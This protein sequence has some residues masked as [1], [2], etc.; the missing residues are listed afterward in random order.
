MEFRYKGEQSAIT[1]AEALSERAVGMG[2]DD[3][4]ALIAQGIVHSGRNNAVAIQSARRAVEVARNNPQNLLNSTYILLRSGEVEEAHEMLLFAESLDPA[5]FEH[6]PSEFKT[7][8]LMQLGRYQE[9]SDYLDRFLTD[10][11]GMFPFFVLHAIIAH[12][13]NQHNRAA[14]LYDRAMA[15]FPDHDG[16]VYAENLTGT[17]KAHLAERAAASRALHLDW[18]ARHG[19]LPSDTTTAPHTDHVSSD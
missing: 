18:L 7:Q 13:L 19:R 3:P 17:D 12:I 10:T 15:L 2:P 5:R 8:V 6:A 4:A 9:A 1:D 14:E 11:S 16:L